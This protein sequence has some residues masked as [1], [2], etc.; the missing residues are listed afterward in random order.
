MQ[1]AERWMQRGRALGTRMRSPKTSI[2]LAIS[3]VASLS[4]V[5][6]PSTHAGAEAENYYDV[7]AW[8]W[9][10]SGPGGGGISNYAGIQQARY[11]SI[12]SGIS[13]VGVSN[14]ELA[15]GAGG[16]V[17]IYQ[18][19][20]IDLGNGYVMEMGT[21]YQCPD[22]NYPNGYEYWYAG[23]WDNNLVPSFTT[24]YFNVIGGTHH[25]TFSIYENACGSLDC[26]RVTIDSTLEKS[27]TVTQVGGG[28]VN[29]MATSDNSSSSH[30]KTTYAVSDMRYMQG[31]GGTWKDFSH[32]NG[33]DTTNT[34][35]DVVTSTSGN[36]AENP[37]NYSN[38]T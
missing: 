6:M 7:G 23:Y 28:A 19:S 22:S 12:P 38:C 2:A 15:Y 20:T 21:G 13:N 26:W 37:S 3:L 5:A 4:V 27:F 24:E 10:G 25:H 14:C 32:T 30:P 1:L 29:W 36:L 35:D 8:F 33:I 18:V 16:S 11:D 31:I 9:D 17:Q 34:C